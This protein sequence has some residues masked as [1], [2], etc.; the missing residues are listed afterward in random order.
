MNQVHDSLSSYVVKCI[1]VYLNKNEKKKLSLF[2]EINFLYLYIS[3]FKYTSI[4]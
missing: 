2:Y 1:Y 4:L 3:N